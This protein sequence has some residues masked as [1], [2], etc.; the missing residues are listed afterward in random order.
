[1]GISKGADLA[2]SMASFLQGVSAVACL[3]GCNAN[4]QSQF[5][6]RGSTMPG[7]GLCT[8]RIIIRESGVLNVRGCYE[9]PQAPE[10][11]ACVVPVERASACFL[12]VVAKDDQVWDSEVYAREVEKQLLSHGRSHPKILTLPGAGHLLEPPYFPSCPA[13]FLK[14]VGTSVEWGGRVGGPR[15][16]AGEMLVPDQGVLPGE[17]GQGDMEAA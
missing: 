10:N 2:L 13:S 12:F 6:Y 3:N 5:H 4:V 15:H 1:M 9:D 16:C 8:D 14:F 17:I 7:L 11:Q